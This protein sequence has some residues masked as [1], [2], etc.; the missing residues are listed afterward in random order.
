MNAPDP[1]PIPVTTRLARWLGEA[2]LLLDP[3]YLVPGVTGLLGCLF[4]L[5]YQGRVSAAF[6]W[7]PRVVGMA[8]LAYAIGFVCCSLGGVIRR[9]VTRSLRPR[10]YFHTRLRKLLISHRLATALEP[11]SAEG[12]ANPW[13][14]YTSARQLYRLMRA[15]L[16]RPGFEASHRA[17]RFRAALATCYD[18]LAAALLVWAAVFWVVPRQVEAWPT[19]WN[20]SLAIGVVLLGLA[21]AS[22]GEAERQTKEEPQEVVAALAEALIQAPVPTSQDA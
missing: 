5:I 8:L 13:S 3:A 14:D 2:L 9:R 22:W 19:P 11:A 10:A 12:A 18:G 4:P 7:S 20:A 15:T 16:A 17:Q 21:F 1:T 6:G